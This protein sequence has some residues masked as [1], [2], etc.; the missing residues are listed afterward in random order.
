M[1]KENFML[2]SSFFAIMLGSFVVLLTCLDMLC[3]GVGVAKF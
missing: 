3:I 1:K 2:V